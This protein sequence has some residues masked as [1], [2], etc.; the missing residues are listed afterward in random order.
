[1]LSNRYARSGTRESGTSPESGKTPSRVRKLPLSLLAS[2]R[3][4]C[5]S[6]SVGQGLDMMLLSPN[7][8]KIHTPTV[9]KRG[10]ACQP[11]GYVP[12]RGASHVPQ[13]SRSSCSWNENEGSKD[14][15][16]RRLRNHE[17]VS[18]FIA[19]VWGIRQAAA[20]RQNCE[21]TAL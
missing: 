2:V 10:S 16:P 7:A 17:K 14:N 11:C 13:D 5:L 9:S 3:R 19:D 4:S 15:R 12:S 21:R 18:K 1:M 6:R 8:R 20:S